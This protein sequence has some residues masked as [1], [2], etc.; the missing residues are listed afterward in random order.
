MFLEALKKSDFIPVIVLDEAD[1]LLYTDANKVLYDLLR[2]VEH[3]KNRLGVISLSNNLNFT[4]ELDARIKSS[5]AEERVLFNPYTPQQLKDI[6]KERSQYAFQPNALGKD[7]IN[8]A[9]AH[10]AKKGGD[11]RVAIEA[12]LKAGRL[13]E[14]NNAPQVSLDHL[15]QAFDLVEIVP[16]QKVLKH[17]SDAE[18]NILKLLAKEKTAI[19]SGQLYE[20]FNKK[21]KAPLTERRLRDLVSRLQTLNLI[22]ADLKEARGKTRMVTLNISPDLIKKE[23]K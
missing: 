8:V 21:K 9:A 16:A 3:Q 22:K 15:K 1:Q 17:L 4:S 18:K 7:V 2:V 19:A 6:L 14:K 13:A 11:A 5:L 20:K 23:L 12:L 10:A